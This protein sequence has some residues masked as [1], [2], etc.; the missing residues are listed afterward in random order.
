MNV[1]C[2]SPIF[3]GLCLGVGCAGKPVTAT[4]S[5]MSELE[6]L[7]IKA[8]SGDASAQNDL[9]IRYA[10]GE[11][12]ATNIDLA[13]YWWRKAAEKG[14]VLSQYHLGIIYGDEKLGAD[15]HNEAFRWYR[16]AAERCFVAAQLALGDLLAHD[17]AG[18]ENTDLMLKEAASWYAKAAN[19]GDWQGQWKLGT[20]YEAGR[21]VK[22]DL[23]EAY[24]WYALALFPRAMTTENVW[25]VS[26]H[27]EALQKRL[28]AAQIE[29]GKSRIARFQAHPI[30]Q[31]A[32]LKSLTPAG[33]KNS[34]VPDKQ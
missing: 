17:A 11:G 7:K 24:K 34:S 31:S 1:I 2:L 13:V 27:L 3:F 23:I 10:Y 29:E 30:D 32:V 28:T 15:Y 8:E 26:R 20:M 12:I 4:V 16:M 14:D 21:G 33:S 6:Q 22:H 19:Q 18:L 25:K 5:R 9:A